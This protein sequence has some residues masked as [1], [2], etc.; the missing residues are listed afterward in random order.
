MQAY[1]DRQI[2]WQLVE[3]LIEKGADLNNTDGDVSTNYIRS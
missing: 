1:T 3:L 2:E